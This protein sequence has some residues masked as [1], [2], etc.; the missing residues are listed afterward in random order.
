MND[1]EADLHHEEYF[2]EIEMDNQSSLNSSEMASSREVRDSLHY[3]PRTIEERNSLV[4]QS[5]NVNPGTREDILKSMIA[6]L[7]DAHI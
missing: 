4:A 2:D 7:N 3:Y 1:S 6:N 5:N